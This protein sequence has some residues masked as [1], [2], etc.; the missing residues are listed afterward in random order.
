MFC[1]A[2]RDRGVEVFEAEQLLAEALVKPEA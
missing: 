1:E 2:M